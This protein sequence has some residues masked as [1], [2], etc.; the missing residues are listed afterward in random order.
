MVLLKLSS[1]FVRFR[2]KIEKVVT[3]NNGYDAVESV[4]TDPIDLAFLD[5]RIR[6]DIDGIA[7]AKLIKERIPFLPLRYFPV[8]ELPLCSTCFGLP[9]ATTMPP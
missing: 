6:G 1:K 9:E 4:Q 7:T 8:I 5:I 3:V 2:F